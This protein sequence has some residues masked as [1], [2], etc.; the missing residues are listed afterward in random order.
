MAE[1]TLQQVPKGELVRFE[2][3]P[4]ETIRA[5]LDILNNVEMKY[6]GKA[7]TKEREVI[8]RLT[9]AA[10]R[11]LSEKTYPWPLTVRFDSLLAKQ[12]DEIISKAR[13]LL[14]NYSRKFSIRYLRRYLTGQST[15]YISG[16]EV[17]V[18]GLLKGGDVMGLNQ[19]MTV[20]WQDQVRGGWVSERVSLELKSILGYR[21]PGLLDKNCTDAFK[22]IKR[23]VIWK[24][25]LFSQAALRDQ[26]WC[27]ELLDQLSTIPGDLQEYVTFYQE[28]VPS[29]RKEAARLEQ[30]HFEFLTDTST[31]IMTPTE[32]RTSSPAES[33]R[34]VTP[35]ALEN[36]ELEISYIAVLKS[37]NE[38]FL[39]EVCPSRI[40]ESA[41]GLLEATKETWKWMADKGFA[42]KVSIKDVLDLTRKMMA[43]KEETGGLN[44]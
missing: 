4:R 38:K 26:K 35:S 41:T 23:A 20:R 21:D 28:W 43:K 29:L 2:I 31:P 9:N 33:D 34:P 42:D 27:D 13:M 5:S 22:K 32:T 39:L 14:P 3:I 18:N 44:I 24:S 37:A 16:V 36:G 17:L 25:Q 12:T 10:G 19:I 15:F 7:Y 40:D 6:L 8:N 1:G 11:L 30:T